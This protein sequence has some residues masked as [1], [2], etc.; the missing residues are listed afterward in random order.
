MDRETQ[1]ISEEWPLDFQSS[2]LPTMSTL[3]LSNELLNACQVFLS[4]KSLNASIINV[5]LKLHREIFS[6]WYMSPPVEAVLQVCT[7]SCLLF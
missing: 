1:K 6:R 2:D 4:C 7:F 5:Y 3:L